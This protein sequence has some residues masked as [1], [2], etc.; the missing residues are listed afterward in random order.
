LNSP[1]PDIASTA[2]RSLARATVGTYSTNLAVAV[3]SFANVLVIARALGAE[4]RGDIALATTIALLSAALA[5]LGVQQANV[6]FA[7]RS[8]ELSDALATNSLILALLLGGLAI[9]AV[10][11]LVTVVPAARGDVDAGLLWVALAS[12]PVL[13]LSTYLQDLVLADYQFVLANIAWLLPPVSQLSVNVVLAASGR[14]TTTAAVGVW[15]AAQSAA[16]ALLVV[17]LLR[18]ATG[19]GRAERSVSA[20]RPTW[21]G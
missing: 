8:P 9:G 6:N 2:E 15:V 21:A 17:R 4:G 12:V 1:S 16:T 11:I 5:N 18:R 10:A 19:F 7:S 13:I 20:R 14:L 3:L